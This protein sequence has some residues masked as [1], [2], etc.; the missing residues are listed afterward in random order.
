ML[1]KVKLILLPIILWY[2]GLACAY[3]L[4]LSP[5]NAPAKKGALSIKNTKEN[6]FLKNSA[7]FSA[8]YD[9]K[10]IFKTEY[11]EKSYD[12]KQNSNGGVDKLSAWA[13]NLDMPLQGDSLKLHGEFNSGQFNS[14][15]NG[16]LSTNRTQQNSQQ[17]LEQDNDFNGLI[18]LGINGKIKGYQYG[19]QYQSVGEDYTKFGNISKKQKN[20]KAGFKYNLGKNFNDFNFEIAYLNTWDSNRSDP[21]G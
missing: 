20:D 9:E 16:Y 2:S 5:Q 12:W 8:V 6:S 11:Q 3:D 10:T 15:R 1:I 4:V 17:S 7:T 19:F 13:I 14:Y 21:Y 18:N